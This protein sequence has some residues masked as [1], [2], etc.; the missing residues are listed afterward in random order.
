M[1]QQ[2]SVALV[3]AVQSEGNAGP[4]DFTFTVT[5]DG[6]PTEAITVDC[7]ITLSGQADAGDF[8]FG[9]AANGQVTIAAGE[10]S[11]DLTL[12]VQGD[13]L[14]EADETFTVSLSNPSVGTLGQASAT[15]TIENDDSVPVVSIGVTSVA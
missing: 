4:T 10:T 12:Q 13:T 1:A 3:Q 6:D 14:V 9:Q 15:G 7:G 2:V 8:V 11:V 5:R